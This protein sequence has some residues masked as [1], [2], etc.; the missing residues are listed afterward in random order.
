MIQTRVT[1]DITQFGYMTTIGL[2]QFHEQLLNR[3]VKP[4][5]ND[6]GGRPTTVHT[7]RRGRPAKLK[8][9]KAKPR[10]RTS[11]RTGFGVVSADVEVVS[12]LL[13][14]IYFSHLVVNLTSL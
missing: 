2:A 5:A 4:I 3:V 11:G 1:K 12:L 8:P 14:E 6:R 13:Y 10:G 7:G 9:L